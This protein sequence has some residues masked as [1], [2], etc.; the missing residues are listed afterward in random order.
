MD[1][2]CKMGYCKCTG[3]Q[4]FAK[5]DDVTAFGKVIVQGY[6]YGD[7]FGN[8]CYKFGE[9]DYDGSKRWALE[10]W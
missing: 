1:K 10:P 9:R 4:G 6:D 5:A 3:N 8:Y 7:D 2:T